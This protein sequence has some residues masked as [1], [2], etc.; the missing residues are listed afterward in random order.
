MTASEQID[1]AL[2]QWTRYQQVR[3]MGHADFVKKAD[4]CN[5]FFSGEQWNAIDK[6]TLALARRPALTINKIL[7]TIGNVMGSRSR[8]GRISPSSR[9]LARR[10]RPQRP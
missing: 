1:T 7:S 6:A 9:V 5:D 3:D 10:L 8:I 4:R 2:R